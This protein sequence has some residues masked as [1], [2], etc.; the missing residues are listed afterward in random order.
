VDLSMAEIDLNVINVVTVGKDQ[1]Y[2][3]GSPTGTTMANVH[4]AQ[5]RTA[6]PIGVP[7]N[8][9]QRQSIQNLAAGGMIKDGAA[10]T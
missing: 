2:P 1:P 6:G 3:T 5:E 4:T 7:N 9:F 8:P 10:G